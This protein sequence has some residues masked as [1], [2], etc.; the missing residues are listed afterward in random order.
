MPEL[1]HYCKYTEHNYIV[2]LAEVCL[3][4]HNDNVRKG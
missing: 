1:T 2:N 4:S 3:V